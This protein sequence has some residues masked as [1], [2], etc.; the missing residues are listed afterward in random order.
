MIIADLT[1]G[2]APII[3]PKRFMY[4]YGQKLRL[5]GQIPEGARADISNLSEPAEVLDIVDNMIAIP[6]KYFLCNRD[7]HIY[8]GEEGPESWNT[9][10]EIVIP[11]E[12]RPAP[13]P[14]PEAFNDDTEGET[15]NDDQ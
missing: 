6:N 12:Y 3:T 14:L 11:I 2:K 5:I 9:R 7:I 4:D 1:Q 13:D 10:R 8:L 15:D